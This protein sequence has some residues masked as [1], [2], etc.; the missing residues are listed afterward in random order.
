MAETKINR[1]WVTSSEQ[2]DE[3]DYLYRDCQFRGQ[4]TSIFVFRHKGI[5]KA[6]RN[7]CVHMPRTLNCE[8]NTIYDE[9][10]ENLRCSMHGIIYDPE[11]GESLSTMCSGQ[12]L[13]SIKV[14]EDEQGI[15]IQDKRIKLLILE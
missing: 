12:K 7:L 1:I 2:L 15:W 6:Y 10:G 11:T 5:C 9:T 8:A 13:T 14:V 4:A 3:G